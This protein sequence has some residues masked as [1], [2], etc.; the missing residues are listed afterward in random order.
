LTGERFEETMRRQ[1]LE[2]LAL[3]SSS[4][5]WADRF[6][7]VMAQGHNTHGIPQGDRQ[8]RVADADSLL[9]T[10]F[11]YATFVAACLWPDPEAGAETVHQISRFMPQ[12]QV[13]IHGNLQ[14][15]L[16]WG[17]EESTDGPF[18][19]HLGGGVGAPF[20]NFVL[21]SRRHGFG[22]VI[23]TNS[24]NGSALFEPLIRWSIGRDFAVFKF[25]QGYF[26]R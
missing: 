7:A 3:G 8:I 19:W 17:I 11:D 6:E 10:A 12:P 25:V 24:A 13:A 22:I 23:L 26:Y 21:A 4:F 20:Q 5:V 18:L 1:V 16:G 14:W 2:P 9:T 15:G